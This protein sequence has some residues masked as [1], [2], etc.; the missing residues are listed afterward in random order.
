M[1]TVERVTV[2][3][4][5]LC[6]KFKKMTETPSA[7]AIVLIS[8]RR[9]VLEFCNDVNT[10]AHLDVGNT[11]ARIRQNFYWPGVQ[12]G[13]SLYITGCEICNLQ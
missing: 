1:D 8:Q 2:Q 3:N 13:A 9:T 7:C 4:V 5:M 12:T 10:A 11:L 6:R